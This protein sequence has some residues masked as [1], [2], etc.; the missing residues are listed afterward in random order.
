MSKVTDQHGGSS[1]PLS[2]FVTKGGTVVQVLSA[3][4]K[5]RRLKVRDTMG[6]KILL[7]G[8]I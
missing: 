3:G 2:N 8:V 7:E 4:L 5:I 1:I 6:G